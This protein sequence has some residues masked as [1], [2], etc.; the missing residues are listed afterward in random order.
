M[1]RATAN[2]AEAAQT[3]PWPRG[4]LVTFARK[5]PRHGA[6]YAPALAL[7]PDGRKLASGH[8]GIR[9]SGHPGIRAMSVYAAPA[10]GPSGRLREGF[11]LRRLH[12]GLDTSGIEADAA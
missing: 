7:T 2:G 5:S 1:C 9:A 10:A 12:N 3:R 8:P 6:D 11:S 4:P